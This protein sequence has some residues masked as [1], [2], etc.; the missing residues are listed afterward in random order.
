[1][2]AFS[3]SR[4][5]PN[6]NFTNSIDFNKD[7]HQKNTSSRGGGPGPNDDSTKT[8][9][10]FDVGLSQNQHPAPEQGSP[11]SKPNEIGYHDRPKN[12]VLDSPSS[13]YAIARIMEQPSRRK[14]F[15]QT[16]QQQM[17]SPVGK[18]N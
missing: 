8:P 2:P 16:Q 13:L 3:P 10:S 1:M 5:R 18:I 17:M 4:N 12:V 6:F 9:S 11:K 14:T 15:H 7:N